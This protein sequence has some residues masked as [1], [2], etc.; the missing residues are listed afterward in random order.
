MWQTQTS[1]VNSRPRM[2]RRVGSA[3]ALNTASSA[4]SCLA[5]VFT[6]V[7]AAIVVPGSRFGR[8]GI[9]IR[10]DKYST[11]SLRSA[12][13]YSSRR[14]QCGRGAQ[15]EAHMSDIEQAVKDKYGAIAASVQQHA[16]KGAGCC[17]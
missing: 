3:S 7:F 2:R 9:Y 1:P 11:A 12:R 4:S 13:L 6:V 14:M 15:Q 17:G 5:A 16:S 10:L 8:S